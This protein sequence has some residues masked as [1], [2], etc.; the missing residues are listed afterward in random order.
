VKSGTNV[1]GAWQLRVADEVGGDSVCS[2]AGRLSVS[3]AECLDGGGSCPALTSALVMSDTPDPVVIGSNHSLYA[4]RH[5]FGPN[6]AKGTVLTHNLPS[7]VVFVQLPH[8]RQREP[9]V[10]GDG[11]P[12]QH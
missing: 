11:E 5:N 10:G 6:T 7:G 9:V 8:P 3:P 12:R 1:N 2:N 4:D